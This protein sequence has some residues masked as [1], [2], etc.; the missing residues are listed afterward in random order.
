[1]SE[2]NSFSEQSMHSVLPVIFVVLLVLFICAMFSGKRSDERDTVHYVNGGIQK[3]EHITN[4]WFAVEVSE[5]NRNTAGEYN[6]SSRTKGVV[7]VDLDGSREIFMKLREGDV[8]TGINNRRIDSLKDFRKVS[9]NINPTEGVLLDIQRN[10]FPMY[11]SINNAGTA[12]DRGP[13]EFQNPHPFSMT[14]V[15]PFLGRD[16]HVGG[17]N[18]ESGIAGKQIE[19]WV[20]STFGGSLNACPKCGTLIPPN[21]YPNNRYISCPN[22]GTKM[23]SK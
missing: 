23:V 1:M 10:G 15:A 7:I 20:K 6:I 5:I 11:I 19:K 21:P 17:I 12:P 2:L 9:Q 18:V 14:E 4:D 8:I 13:F 22:C 3:G 16:I